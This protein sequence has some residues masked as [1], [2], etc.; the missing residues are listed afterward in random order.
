MAGLVVGTIAAMVFTQSLRKEGP[1]AS[2][3]RFKDKKAGG[4][5]RVCFRLP[6]ED[7]VDL[8]IVASGS[9]EVVKVLASGTRL[10]GGS[11]DSDGD[12]EDDDGNAHCFEWDGTDDGGAPVGQGIYRLRLTLRDADRSGVSGER[13]RIDG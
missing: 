13:L 4:G 3:I 6:R 8:E 9:R 11:R 5:Y 2:E 10:A 12:G 1:I 7:T